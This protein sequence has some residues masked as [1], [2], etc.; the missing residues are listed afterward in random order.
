[1]LFDPNKRYLDGI[2]GFFILLL[3]LEAFAV[4]ESKNIGILCQ[5]HE[6]FEFKWREFFLC[7]IH[8]SFKIVVQFEVVL[9][10]FLTDVV[11]ILSM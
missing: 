2:I 9:V 5:M 10:E 3:Q 8:C 4:A 6:F 7:V 1:M 11:V